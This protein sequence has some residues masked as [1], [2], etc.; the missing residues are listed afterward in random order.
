M[1]RM[2]AAR[3]GLRGFAPGGARAL[4]FLERTTLE[5]LKCAVGPS[6]RWMASSPFTL[7]PLEN[8][9]FSLKM[10]RSVNPPFL[11]YSTM[12]FTW[13]DTSRC[14]LEWVLCLGGAPNRGPGL[15]ISVGAEQTLVCASM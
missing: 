1:E 3:T 11:A 7:A 13:N 10:R 2:Q 4:I 12:R 15:D 9:A 8:L 6:G 14:R 5:T